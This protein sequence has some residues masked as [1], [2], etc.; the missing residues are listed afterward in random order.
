[1][2]EQLEKCKR[3]FERRRG[4][5]RLLIAQNSALKEHLENYSKEEKY[6]ER[7]QEL[8]KQAAK[9]TQE[10]LEYHISEL[11][12]LA[13]K[14]VFDDPY[15]MKVKFETKA[16]RTE[17]RV[18]FE[19]DGNEISPMDASG[20]GVVDVASFALRVSLWSLKS[21]RSCNTLILDEP[22]KML[23]RDLLPKAGE[24]LKELSRR[25]GIQFIVVT[26]SQ[27][28]IDNADKVFEVEKKSGISTVR[29][30]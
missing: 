14:T 6:I 18:V 28:L 29:E 20:G 3:E 23:S 12:S 5:L 21:P 16:D 19:K 27:D 22:F 13:M 30:V 1:M 17:A 8:I 25:L 24:V 10:E 4:S 7:A 2:R 9:N 11:V 15:E 26:H